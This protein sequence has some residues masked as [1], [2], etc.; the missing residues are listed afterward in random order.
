MHQ[1]HR[2]GQRNHW[3]K[4]ESGHRHL[5][6]GMLDTTGHAQGLMPLKGKSM[7]SSGQTGVSSPDISPC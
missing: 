1:L 5:H 3:L 2:R 6:P 7:A 4:P